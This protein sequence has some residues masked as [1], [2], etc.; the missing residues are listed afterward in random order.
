MLIGITGQIGSGKTEAAK[1]FARLGAFVISAD[2]IGKEVVEKDSAIPK[3]LVK[4]FGHDILT[5]TGRLRRKYLARLAF[6]SEI[7]K[8]KLNK[9]VHPAL[10]KELAKQARAAI[11]KHNIVVIDAA[12]LLDW[13][14]DKKVDLTIVIHASDKTK[15][16]RLTGKGY[17]VEEARMRLRSQLKYQVF[18]ARADIIIH[19]NKTLNSLELRIK[20][21]L[22]KVTP[23]RVDL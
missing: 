7:Q 9:I 8:K 13:G 14:W 22:E 18:K 1:I 11:K 17:S 19:N 6:S 23:K 10:L 20:K 4:A 3:K 15:I 12:L 16:A 2:R 5:P 21:I